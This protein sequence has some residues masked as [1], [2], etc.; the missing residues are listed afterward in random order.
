MNTKRQYFIYEKKSLKNGSPC[1]SFEANNINE[2]IN[3]ALREYADM[4]WIL[5]SCN[6]NQ[7]SNKK[8][9]LLHVP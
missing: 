8:F 7:Q 2:A 6:K 9:E 4:E 5:M 1:T 3:I